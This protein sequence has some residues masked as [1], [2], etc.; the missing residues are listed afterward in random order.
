MGIFKANDI[1]G[2]FPGELTREVIYSLGYHLPAV[3]KTQEILVGWDGRT[4]SPE[5]FEILSRGITDAGA[6]V[7][8]LG[9]CDT[10]ALYFATFAYGYGGSVMITASHNPPADNGL[11]ISGKDAVPLGP[12]TGLKE[13]EAL[14]GK[15]TP[16]KPE[17]GTVATR[18]IR[19]DYLAHVRRF[20]PASIPLR[21]VFDCGNGAACAYAADIF[22]PVLKESWFLY[23]TPDG[24]FPHHGP[25]PLESESWTGIRRAI[26]AH[27]ADGGI[28]FDG[29]ADRAVFFDEEGRFISPDII[30]A[31]LSLHFYKKEGASGPMFY[32]IRSSRSV[33]EYVSR[34]GGEARVCDTGHARI[35]KLLKDENGVYAGELSGHYYFRENGYCDSGFITA[36][37]VLGILAET[38]ESLS[39]LVRSINPYAFS[40]E[41]NF[42]VTNQEAVIQGLTERYGRGK[43]T[44][45][46][47][48]RVDFDT[49]W[50]ILRP[51][52][53]EPVLRLVV[54]A[55]DQEELEGRVE[56]IG[57]VID[58]LEENYT[59]SRA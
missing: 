49:W 42:K 35:K 34:Q 54:E 51:S 37:L 1:R 44:R 53:A 9:F 31:L 24:T 14:L 15:P 47:G 23:P 18:D 16:V 48:V 59:R 56:E 41:I 25:N 27:K 10:P 13:L 32:D 7:H 38:G 12:D 5:I 6:H 22:Q 8:A 33:A 26:G 58:H 36:A 39:D 50:F 4:S 20:A 19:Q 52:G 45:R 17:R 2:I 30:T 57:T 43:I 3:L 29:D 11:K 21:I 40:G 46:D 28:L 55:A